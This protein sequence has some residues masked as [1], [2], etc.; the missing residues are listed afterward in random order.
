VTPHRAV[1]LWKKEFSCKI[2]FR[3]LNNIYCNS[4]LIEREEAELKTS[5]EK[6]LRNRIKQATKGIAIFDF[7][8]C[9]SRGTGGYRDIGHACENKKI[10]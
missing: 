4:S 9:G 3:F 8:Q 10:K 2:Y 6:E 1:Y 5:V 7:L